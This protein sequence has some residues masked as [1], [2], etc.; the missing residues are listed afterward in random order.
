[1][2]SPSLSGIWILT[3]YFQNLSLY[4]TFGE[5]EDI[6]S[7]IQYSTVLQK[8]DPGQ[9][10]VILG[11]IPSQSISKS[12]T[13]AVA[14]CVPFLRQGFSAYADSKYTRAEISQSLHSFCKILQGK[15]SAN[16]NPLQIRL[17]KKKKR[18]IKPRPEV[19]FFNIQVLKN[20]AIRQCLKYKKYIPNAHKVGLTKEQ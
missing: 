2:K 5:S 10:P 15:I 7:G 17:Q 18:V 20:S 11:Q 14:D 9:F 4:Q 16:V 6:S 3:L 13:K 12:R 19:R 1:M 8:D